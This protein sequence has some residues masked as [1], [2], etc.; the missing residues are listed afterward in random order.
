MATTIVTPNQQRLAVESAAA[1]RA[2]A[3]RFFAGALPAQAE[4]AAVNA[5]LDAAEKFFSRGRGNAHFEEACTQIE[6]CRRALRGESDSS[7]G[8]AISAQVGRSVRAAVRE[9]GNSRGSA[10]A[11]AVGAAT[12]KAMRADAD[13]CALLEVSR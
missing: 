6:R 10:I 5:E 9:A 2:A 3:D 11:Q 1:I 4:L 12:L 7:R 13:R 8:D